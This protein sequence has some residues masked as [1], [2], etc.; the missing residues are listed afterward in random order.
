LAFAYVLITVI[1][2]LTVPLAVN[3]RARAESELLGQ[4]QVTVQAIASAFD[5]SSLAPR[6][7]SRLARQAERYSDEISGRVLVMDA[8]GVVLADA[9][10]FPLPAASAVGED[11]A[12]PQRPEVLSALVDGETAA[13][14]RT[15]EE[16]DVD[17]LLASA[18]IVD[19]PAGRADVIGAVRITLDVQRVT[20]SVRRATL[21]VLVIGLGGL[22]AGMLVA[23]VLSGSLARPLRRLA[24]AARR[25]GR[26]DLSARMGELTG[27]DEVREVAGSFD[28]MADRVERTFVAQRSFV[29]NASHQLRT[30]LTG[31]R[32]RVERAIDETTD[33]DLR[34]QLESAER[35]IDRM[36]ATV[37]RMLQLASEI[38]EGAPTEAD[39][40]EAARAGAARW[41]NRAAER[42]ASVTADAAGAAFVHANPTDLE[43]IVDNLLDN[44]T[45]Y[46]P[47]PVEL[48]VSTGSTST[49]LAIRDHGPGIP[50][51]EQEVA[52]QRFG[53]G[54]GAP[55]GGSGLGLSIAR[56]LTERWGGT[57]E[58]VAPP[59]GGTRV[60]VRLRPASLPRDGD[61]PP[62]GV[63]RGD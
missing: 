62:G 48:S 45:V 11:Y 46:A 2:A 23:F 4:A 3:Q 40:A 35:E 26:G 20:D 33:P 56:E 13:L 18:P 16:L 36:A 24:E 53:R 52:L 50:K 21:G 39:V 5:E 27:P 17:L 28:E 12:T 19:G 14:V 32:L 49:V 1:V 60:E 8:G 9:N 25:F 34:T 44:A 15:S 38:E 43:Q 6:S 55:A 47:G 42:G 59:D 63:G 51:E 10:P 29:A 7:R 57:L 54:T 61:R 37:D 58:L 41:A 30:P 22:L 31:M